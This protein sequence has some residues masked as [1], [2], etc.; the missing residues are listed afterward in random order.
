VPEPPSQPLSPQ[1]GQNLQLLSVL[2]YVYA[3]VVAFSAVVFAFVAVLGLVLMP[4]PGSPGLPGAPK[5][6][7]LLGGFFLIIFGLVALFMLAQSVVMI[8]AGRACARR[9]SYAICVVAA[10]VALMH[11]PLGTALGVF[12]LMTLTKPAVRELLTGEAR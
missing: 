1:D 12:A 3:G 4:A 8:L 7:A 9:S 11:F 10:G 2:F 6:I 5:E